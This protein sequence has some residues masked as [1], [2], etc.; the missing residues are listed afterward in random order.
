MY[1][2]ILYQSPLFTNVLKGEE[3]NADLMVNGYEYNYRYYL[4]D[5]LYPSVNTS[6]LQTTK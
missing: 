2:N 5:D 6:L 3:L 1:F 4:L